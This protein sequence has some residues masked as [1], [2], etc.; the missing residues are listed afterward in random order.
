VYASAVDRAVT[1]M[2]VRVLKTSG[3][4]AIPRRSPPV[5]QFST[6]VPASG[7][8]GG[9]AMAKQAA[10]VIGLAVATGVLG[11]VR[12]AAAQT[13]VLHVID[14]AHVSRSELAEAEKEATQIY[15]RSGVRTTWVDGDVTSAI[16][17]GAMHLTIIMLARNASAGVMDQ[18]LGCA[19]HPTHAYVYHDRIAAFAR[20]H[21]VG[22]GVLLGN[23][24]AHEIGHLLLPGQGHSNDG[25]MQ[26]NITVHSIR[27]TP[28]QG[29][30]IRVR[31]AA[32]RF[33]D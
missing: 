24:I 4:G 18:T 19:P 13:L 28:A 5:R 8:E 3:N 12:L 32:A 23:V 29:D 11:T 10:K 25:I 30:A 7:S 1:A 21:A 16:D 27:F 14:Y 31:V 33:K 2:S 26:A 6:P 17:D 9:T 15:E 20:R 22:I